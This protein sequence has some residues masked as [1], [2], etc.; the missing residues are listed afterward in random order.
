[1]GVRVSAAER[2]AASPPSDP[3][4]YASRLSIERS[5]RG[6]RVALLT[7]DASQP[8]REVQI[9]FAL[10]LDI[11][12]RLAQASGT[13]EEGEWAECLAKLL[14][15]AEL[16][17]AFGGA[18][19]MVISCD[20]ETARVHWEMLRCG[21]VTRQ[22]KTLHA[23]I[24]P[25]GPASGRVLIVADTCEEAPLAAAREEGERLA[26]L[27]SGLGL[28]VTALIGPR[29]AHRAAVVRELLLREYGVFH[30]A[31]HCS[32]STDGG[33]GWLFSGGALLGANE[34]QRVDR[35]PAFVFS[36]ACESGRMG[37]SLMDAAGFAESFFARGVQNLVCTAWPVGDG[38][39]A[40]FAASVY[41]NADKPIHLAL[42]EA[43]KQSGARPGRWQHYGNPFYRIFPKS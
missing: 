13:A 12:H 19:P 2:R 39:A 30:F 40:A 33:S 17:N 37:P 34:L 28:E 4:E 38:E 3:S 8:E 16:R 10:A 6:V 31:G 21:S 20:A 14:L 15:P 11:N 23:P 42:A 25:P 36:N 43:R 24:L 22:L 26:E 18:G 7:G 9:D 1:M 35:V 29:Q 5:A 27:L 41:Q 32:Y